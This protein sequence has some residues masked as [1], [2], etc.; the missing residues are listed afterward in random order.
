MVERIETIAV[1]GAAIYGADAIAGTVNVILKDDFEGLEINANY[2]E[3]MDNRDLEEKTFSVVFGNNFADD[4]GNIVMSFEYNDREGLIENQRDHLA[5]GWQFREPAGDSD[6]RRVL[7]SN[8]HA[9]IV[10]P[11]GA[12]TPG[13]GL[14]R[15]SA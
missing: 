8:A 14:L 15:I 4:R 2:G 1:G 11:G 6:F 13:G 12:I 5:A 7:V 10:G 3:A 9:N